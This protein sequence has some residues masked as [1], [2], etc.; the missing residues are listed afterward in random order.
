MSKMLQP[1]I[2][3]PTLFY[4]WY[5]AVCI[6]SLG[7]K[8]LCTNQGV[9]SHNHQHGLMINVPLVQCVFGGGGYGDKMDVGGWQQ[10]MVCGWRIAP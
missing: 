8:T 6:I 2:Q 3:Y 4:F 5:R 7:K 10:W 9:V 1:N